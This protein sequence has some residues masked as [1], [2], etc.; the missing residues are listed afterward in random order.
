MLSYFITV[1]TLIAVFLY[2]FPNAKV[3][4]FLTLLCQAGLVAFSSWLFF[5]S[6][7]GEI[8]EAVGNF[9]WVLGVL[10]K[11]DT[12]SVAFL[13]LSSFTFLIITFYT[14]NGSA[15]RLFLL[16]LFVWQGVINGIFLSRDLF[17]LFVLIEVKTVVAAILIMYHK[18][19]R[20]IYDGMLYLMINTAAV[21]FYLFGVGYIYKMTGVFNMD[22]A[23]DAIA[24]LD[25]SD[26]LLPFALIMMPI[27]LKC[28][29]VPLYSWL[30]RAHG[31]PG[32]PTVVSAI[33]SGLHIKTAV[34]LFVRVMEMFPQLDASWFFLIV[35]IVTGI[36]G[37]MF[38][39]AQTDIKLILAYHTVS[40]IGMIMIGLNLGDYY[41][42]IGGLYHMFNHALFKS[43]LFLCAGLIS[44]T[45]HTRDIYKISGVLRR[46]P[47]VGVATLMAAMGI[48]GT[49]IFNGSISKYF[50][51]ANA[52]PFING[53]LIFINLGTIVSFI[54]FSSMLFGAD[55][56]HSGE[57]YKYHGDMKVDGFKQIAVLVLGTLC[58]IGGFFGEAFI[59]V[60][61]HVQVGVDTM[62]Y[63]E[64][65]LI[66]LGS[67]VAGFFLYKYFVK[68]SRLFVIL[69]GFE[70]GFRGMCILMGVFFAVML[71]SLAFVG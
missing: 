55:K 15:S 62:G 19:N 41:A 71:L 32:A 26:L 47:F 68:K 31:T 13:L 56:G 40:Q 43:A 52:D 37:F 65:S 38:A 1:P 70:I 10:L 48:T 16:M 60:L 23:A 64:K 34:Y 20:S 58:L 67:A 18:G 9:E 5:E 14:F 6:R 46:M 17:N 11:A 3:A 4:K 59:Y 30:P 2:I 8:V 51:G 25:R 53:A 33:L 42:H 7:G 63:I 21:L 66:F 35:G 36:V 50:I 45:Y 54:K 57:E 69:R 27:C 44:H 39:L 28:A 24:Y 22:A 61:L 49:P 29:L 12:L